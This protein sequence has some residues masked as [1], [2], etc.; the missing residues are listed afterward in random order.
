MVLGE[1]KTFFS[2]E[3]TY[4]QWFNAAV[5]VASGGL[6]VMS[7]SDTKTVGILLVL[8]STIIIMYSTF[9]YYRRNDALVNRR[10]EGYNDLYGPIVLSGIMI[11]TFISLILKV[12]SFYLEANIILLSITLLM[13]GLIIWMLIEGMLS[14]KN[15][16]HNA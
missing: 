1:P 9:I 7:L 6:T 16:N 11:I 5:F 4:L 2:N 12:K 15:N 8:V 10:P 14:I 3:R 13:L